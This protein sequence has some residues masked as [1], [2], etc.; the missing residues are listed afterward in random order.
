[1]SN[2]LT[3]QSRPDNEVVIDDELMKFIFRIHRTRMEGEDGLKEI[4]FKLVDKFKTTTN[5]PDWERELTDAIRWTA[6]NAW[7]S[8]NT[9]PKAKV[10]DNDKD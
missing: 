9:E 1:M 5:N 3:V 7:T 4:Y 6:G 8:S 2:E 10:N